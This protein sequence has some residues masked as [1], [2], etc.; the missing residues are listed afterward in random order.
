[1]HPKG[2][3]SVI[4]TFALKN[5]HDIEI[6]KVILLDTNEEL[7]FKRTEDGLFVRLNEERQD[8]LPVCFKIQLA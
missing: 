2:T 8:S 6:E 4:K 5:A 1:M 7:F 3:E